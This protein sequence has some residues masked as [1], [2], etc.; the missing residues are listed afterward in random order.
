MIEALRNRIEG[1]IA[2]KIG[3]T[4]LAGWTI[5]LW[6]SHL[7]DRPD[8]LVSGLWCALTAIVVVQANIGGTYKAG[9]SRFLGVFIGSLLGGIF[10]VILGSNPFS[11][12][13]SV[14]ITVIVCTLLN[15]SDSVRIASMSVA[16]VMIM[17]KLHP[18]MSPWVFAF[19]RLIDSALGILI[20][21]GISHL[22]WPFPAAR[23]VRLNTANI[24][25]VLHQLLLM[26]VQ[27][28]EWDKYKEIEYLKR[29][30]EIRT[31]FDQ[32]TLFLEESKMEMMMTPERLESWSFLHDCL[33]DL[34]DQILSLKRV[35]HDA[36]HFLNEE[37]KDQLHQTVSSIDEGLKFMSHQ[38]TLRKGPGP[39]STMNQSLERLQ[40][41]LD[42]FS[43]T[44][45]IYASPLSDIEKFFVCFYT[46][47][48]VGMEMQKIG[49]KID[50]MYEGAG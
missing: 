38:L 18:E 28:G 44:H 39:L 20:G 47:D 16:V 25:F 1:K 2:I 30:K 36:H 4:A 23:N 11:L 27:N 45:T 10:T 22:I 48:A 32:N 33:E 50:Q 24:L 42:L 19:Y 13:I 12:G 17:W 21:I 49:H 34:F 8:S 37:L 7:F 29:I 46:L 9:L 26:I 3:I 40:G 35:F 31:V 43:K 5:G 14:G 6:F 41:K 15:M